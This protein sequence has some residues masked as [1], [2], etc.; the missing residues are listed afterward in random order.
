M[1]AWA[2]DQKLENVKMIP[3]GNGRVC[4]RYGNALSEKR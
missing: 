1:N 3:D 2:T 4:T